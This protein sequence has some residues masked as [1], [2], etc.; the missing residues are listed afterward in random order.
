MSPRGILYFIVSFIDLYVFHLNDDEMEII[1][2]VSWL[3][4][5]SEYRLIH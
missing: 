5:F 2:V 3:Y 1:I 4:F